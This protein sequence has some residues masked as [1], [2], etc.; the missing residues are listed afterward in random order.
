MILMKVKHRDQILLF[1]RAPTCITQP[2]IRTC[3]VPDSF[4]VHPSIPKSYGQNQNLEI[5]TYL[6]YFDSSNRKSDFDMDVEPA[7]EPIQH[8]SSRQCDP[9]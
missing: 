3:P 1:F 6:R 5:A 2:M 4:V 9:P 7:Y 8:P